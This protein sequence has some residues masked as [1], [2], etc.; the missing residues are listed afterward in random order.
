[1]SVGTALL[2]AL[3]GGLGSVLRFLLDRAVTRATH[4]DRPLGTLAVNVVGSLLIGVA[5]GIA[6][7]PAA[8]IVVGTGAIGGFTTFSTWML[9]TLELAHRGGREVAWAVANVVGS[10]VLGVGAVLLGGAL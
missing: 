10:V 7:S 4:G 9:E 1:M 3:A 5:G 8:A 6:L 2:T